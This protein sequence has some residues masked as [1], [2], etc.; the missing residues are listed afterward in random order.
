MNTSFK[1]MT[2]QLCSFVKT[3]PADGSK[4]VADVQ[5]A[6]LQ[7]R[8]SNGGQLVSPYLQCMPIDC[9]PVNIFGYS[10]WNK[11]MSADTAIEQIEYSGDA[12]EL[13][14]ASTFSNILS[15]PIKGGLGKPN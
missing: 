11:P 4:L 15:M 5:L 6:V 2:E 1:R 3:V 13:L 7:S 14:P 10:A 9:G 12:E 8:R